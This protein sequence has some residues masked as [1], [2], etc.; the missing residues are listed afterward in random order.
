MPCPAG[1]PCPCCSPALLLSQHDITSRVQ[2]EN[3]L[4]ELTEAQLG[5]LAQVRRLNDWL[6][7]PKLLLLSEPACHAACRSSL[8]M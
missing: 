5:M 2:L 8:G 4:T 3:M 6:L 7:L 1:L